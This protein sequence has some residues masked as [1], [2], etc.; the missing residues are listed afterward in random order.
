MLL[1]HVDLIEKLL[2]YNCMERRQPN[3]LGAAS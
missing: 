2:N 1:S 3:M